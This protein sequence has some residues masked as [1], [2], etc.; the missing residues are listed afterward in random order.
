MLVAHHYTRAARACIQG[1]IRDS[2]SNPLHTNNLTKTAAKVPHNLVVN[3]TRHLPEYSLR[4]LQASATTS[5]SECT[6]HAIR[7]GHHAIQQ[8]GNACP[9]SPSP[10]PPPLPRP[11]SGLTTPVASTPAACQAHPRCCT[12]RNTAHLPD[13]TQQP[14]ATRLQ[15]Q[16][17]M[18]APPSAKTCGCLEVGLG[19]HVLLHPQRQTLGA[20]AP[21][22][23]SA[24]CCRSGMAMRCTARRM[25]LTC[26]YPIQMRHP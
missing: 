5:G 8:A 2:A 11:V 24:A 10:P 25:H 13:P 4:I 9:P 18:P 21:E 23:M 22:D 26:A 6:R 12:R 17:R 14:A 20:V 1:I 7:M 3:R 19:V 15:N 16:Q